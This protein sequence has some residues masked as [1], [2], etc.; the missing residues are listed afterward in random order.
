MIPIQ[1]NPD[2]NLATGGKI[3]ADSY[4]HTGKRLMLT[5]RSAGV[6]YGDCWSL[7]FPSRKVKK[8][9]LIIKLVD[10]ARFSD[11]LNKKLESN[12]KK[13]RA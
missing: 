3:P 2:V 1:Q 7:V 13:G 5:A 8:C 9:G 12:K 6:P 11:A 4:L 10:K